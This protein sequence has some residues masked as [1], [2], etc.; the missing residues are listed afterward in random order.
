M[1]KT[2]ET[3]SQ[4][5]VTMRHDLKEKKNIQKMESLWFEIMRRLKWEPPLLDP[6]SEVEIN[7]PE[8]NT[9]MDRVIEL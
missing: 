9:Y 4:V 1:I 6:I 8:Y 2:V 7:E 3:M 5:Q